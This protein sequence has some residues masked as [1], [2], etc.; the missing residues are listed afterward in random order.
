MPQ[1]HNTLSEIKYT[2]LHMYDQKTNTNI[3][4]YQEKLHI[5]KEVTDGRLTAS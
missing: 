5:S 4:R 1:G 3:K 2:Q